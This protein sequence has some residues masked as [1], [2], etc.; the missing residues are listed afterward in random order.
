MLSAWRD[1]I[2]FLLLF[3]IATLVEVLQTKLSRKATRCIQGHRFQM[4]RADVAL[5]QVFG[6]LFSG[7]STLCLGGTVCSQILSRQHDHVQSLQAFVDA[8]QVSRNCP[9]IWRPET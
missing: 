6:A 4:A 9:C 5:E 1:R 8:V 2:S 7:D 3:G